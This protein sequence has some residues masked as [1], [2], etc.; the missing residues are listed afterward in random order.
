M[1]PIAIKAPESDGGSTRFPVIT[2]YI[3]VRP[4]Y[5]GGEPHI[6]G[7]R[8]KVRHVAVWHEERRYV[9]ELKAQSPR[10]K[11]KSS[12]RQGSSMPRTMCL[13]LDECCDPAI[14]RAF[15]FTESM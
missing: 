1:E 4:G 13:H 8:I 14:A 15:G 6:L 10:Q 5:C 2:E 3:G 7:H 11:L 9:E 12:W